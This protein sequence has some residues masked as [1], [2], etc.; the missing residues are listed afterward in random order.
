MLFSFEKILINILMREKLLSSSSMKSLGNQGIFLFIFKNNL[1]EI[2][3]L[4]EN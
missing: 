3:F 2:L 4:L 1:L